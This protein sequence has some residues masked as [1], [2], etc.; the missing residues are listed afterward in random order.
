MNK[1]QKAIAKVSALPRATQE[2]IA[3]DLIL[4]VNDVERLR[5]E[6]QEAIASLDYSGGREVQIEEVIRAA[7]AEYGGQ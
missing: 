7:R 1:L 4:H 3:E 6:L 5:A 2:R